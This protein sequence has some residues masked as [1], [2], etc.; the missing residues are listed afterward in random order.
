MMVCATVPMRILSLLNPELS[1]RTAE[2]VASVTVNGLLRGYSLS[3]VYNLIRQ[4]NN[5][6]G[7][8]QDYK[9]TQHCNPFGMQ[10]P[11]W[12]VRA[13]GSVG[14]EGQAI[15]KTVNDAVLDRLDWDKRNGITGKE[16][17]YLA[18]VQDAG[19][20]PNPLYPVVVGAYDSLSSH[21]VR[22]ITALPVAAILVVYLLRNF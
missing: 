7:N 20:N 9:F 22:V 4:F 13:I 12:S 1:S 11:T 2:L 3:N 16:V 17:E 18:K 8:G 19:Y 6:T 5:E 15:Y 21:V 14:L 10:R